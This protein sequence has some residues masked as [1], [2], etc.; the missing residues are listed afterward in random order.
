MGGI[1]IAEYFSYLRNEEIGLIIAKSDIVEY[2]RD[3]R[4]SGKWNTSCK[5]NDLEYCF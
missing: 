2:P 1:I 4:N 5:P 3:R